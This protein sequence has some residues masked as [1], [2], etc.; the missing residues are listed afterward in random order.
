[1]NRD[2]VPARDL[3]D[4]LEPALRR[5]RDEET[6]DRRPWEELAEQLAA[7]ERADLDTASHWDQDGGDPS[8]HGAA[9]PVVDQRRVAGVVEAMRHWRTFCRGHRLVSGEAASL[10]AIRTFLEGQR[11]RQAADLLA[12]LPDDEGQPRR[13]YERL[14]VHSQGTD[15]SEARSFTNGFG[16]SHSLLDNEPGRPL[17]GDTSFGNEGATGGGDRLR[18]PTPLA[19]SGWDA[20]QVGERG[21][22]PPTSA[23]ILRRLIA[24]SRRELEA[25]SVLETTLPASLSRRAE[26]DRLRTALLAS[27]ADDPPDG[28][29]LDGQTRALLDQAEMVQTALEDLPLSVAVEQL[30]RVRDDLDWHLAH[31]IT[32]KS[33]RRSRLK[34]KARQIRSA[35]QERVAQLR[36][37]R[38]FGRRGV[39]LIQHV[40]V[41]LVLALTGLTIVEL[42]AGL[43][44]GT[45]RWFGL[46]DS[47]IC[48][49]LL[50]EFTVRW[51]HSGWSGRYFLNHLLTDI[52]PS[53]PV[54]ALVFIAPTEESGALEMIHLGQFIRLLRLGQVVRYVW[55]LRPV[56]WTLRAVALGM[57]WLDRIVARLGPLINQNVILYP[58]REEVE[59]ASAFFPD[60]DRR[61]RHRMRAMQTAWR[62]LVLEAPPSL[63]DALASVRPRVLEERLGVAGRRI[64]EPLPG[65]GPLSTRDIPAA[66]LL[67]R[68]VSV[69]AEDVEAALERD[70]IRQFATVVRILARPPLRWLPGFRTLPA[71][72]TA[73]MTDAEATA[74]GCRRLSSELRRVHHAAFVLADLYGAFSPAEVL[75]RLGGMLVKSSFRPA[76]QLIVFGGLYVLIVLTLR[77]TG[78]T[79]L[80]P[81]TAWLSKTVS[82]TLLVIGAICGLAVALGWW[83]QRTSRAA[84]EFYDRFAQAQFLALTEV[85]RSRNLDRDCRWLHERILM[86]EAQ[87]TRLQ[88]RFGPPEEDELGLSAPAPVSGSEGI[89]A[90]EQ[91]SQLDCVCHDIRRALI[92]GHIPSGG[93]FGL[94]YERTILLYRDWIDG[95]MFCDNDARV[96]SQLLGNPALSHLISLSERIRPAEIRRLEGLDLLRPKSLLFG[97]HFWFRLLTQATGQAVARK[98]VEYNLSAIPVSE[99]DHCDPKTRERYFAWLRRSK[100]K[101]ERPTT[102]DAQDANRY[103]TTSFHALHFLDVDSD[104]D[105]EVE[106]RFG[107]ELLARLRRDRGELTR[108]LYG[109]L[110][111]HRRPREARVVNLHRLYQDYVAGGRLLI[112]PIVL[113]IGFVKAIIWAVRWLVKALQDARQ[114]LRSQSHDLSE[115][116]LLAAYRKIDRVRG[117][118]HVCHDSAPHTL[119]PGI[120]RRRA[121]AEAGVFACRRTGASRFR[122][123]RPG[124]GCVGRNR[125]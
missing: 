61:H 81:V 63:R 16:G 66:V 36:L 104:R 68:L 72:A 83:V 53:L 97:P 112:L 31:V 80:E 58:T 121:A 35:W 10:H 70:M 99:L 78:I 48:L 69:T 92:D 95:A 60:T 14:A 100:A 19:R 47:L 87:I 25:G 55:I 79:A 54:G 107:P 22:R 113:V 8:E 123:P 37:E 119:G 64:L 44:A 40:V 98:L 43:P 116:D 122:P 20:T 27:L 17:D 23:E 85:I 71:G 3:L 56:F 65:E 106:R 46:V 33:P 29:A 105:Q 125:T 103:H 86:P 111:L 117:A 101:P 9:G 114:P 57:R 94:S 18:G 24:L 118:A 91:I 73:S 2:A 77:L 26:R 93:P 115:A 39:S 82:W 120:P 124:A 28:D 42:T 52:V 6:L 74:V 49:V 62:R 21:M 34:R 88:P 15:E 59:A 30:V 50:T 1:M 90:K 84:T 5:L 110:P 89:P 7:E 41:I 102:R 76:Y 109:T 11:E 32:R 4:D 51:A 45:H 38:R 13:D 75:T 96:A 108:R 12:G 67:E